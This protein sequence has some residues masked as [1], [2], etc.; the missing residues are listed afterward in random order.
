MTTTYATPPGF[1]RNPGREARSIECEFVRRLGLLGIRADDAAAIRQLFEL[2]GTDRGSRQ[3][4]AAT[5]DLLGLG[6]LLVKLL[7]QSAAAGGEL[8]LEPATRAFVAAMLGAPAAKRPVAGASLPT[9][10]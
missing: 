3:Q 6:L 10:G 2:A 1:L 5:A 4:E 9:A 8:T 7:C